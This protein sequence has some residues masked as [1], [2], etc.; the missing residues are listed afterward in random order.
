MKCCFVGHRD[1]F[2]IEEKIDASIEKL[3]RNGVRRFYSGGMG[4]FDKMC[5]KSVKKLGGRLIFVPYNVKQI[6]EEHRAWHDEIVCPFG[7]KA[8]EKNDIPNRNKWMVDYSDIVISYV[9]KPGGANVTLNY[10]KRANKFIVDL[11]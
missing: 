5:E 10:A 11:T 2:G 8:Y 9:Y 1:C 7:G 4:N 6:K 3:M